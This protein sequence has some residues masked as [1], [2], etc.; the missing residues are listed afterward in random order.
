MMHLWVEKYQAH[1]I[2]FLQ[3][4]NTSPRNIHRVRRFF[5]FPAVKK[6]PSGVQTQAVKTRPNF[7]LNLSPYNAR[8]RQEVRDLP[9]QKIP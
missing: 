6:P 4:V 2:T 7:S 8:H 5:V 1:I 3:F 9:M